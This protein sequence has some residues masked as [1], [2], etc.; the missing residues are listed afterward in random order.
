MANILANF[1]YGHIILNRIPDPKM[2]SIQSSENCSSCAY[3][4]KVSSLSFYFLVIRPIEYAGRC[5]L[6]VPT[7]LIGCDDGTDF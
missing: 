5:F 6:R 2:A 7:S 3:A 4:N 1:Y